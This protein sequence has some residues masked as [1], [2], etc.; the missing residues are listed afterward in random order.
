MR[1]AMLRFA[2][3]PR[4]TEIHSVDGYRL[5]E[6]SLY[7]SGQSGEARSRHSTQL[8]A[9]C[10]DSVFVD[11]R[12]IGSGQIVVIRDNEES[13]I[14]LRSISGLT[15]F[16][17]QAT[18]PCYLDMTGLTH[19]TWAA[20]LKGALVAK[21]DLRVVYVEPVHYRFNRIRTQGEL[22]DLSERF[23]GIGPLPGFLSLA[24]PDENDVIFVPLLGFEGTRFSMVL[25]HVEVPRERIVPIVGVPGF[26]PEFVFYAYQGNRLPLEETRS[27]MEVQYAAANCPF[28]LFYKLEDLLQR[29]DKAFFRIAPIGTKP[30][31]LGAILF[32][33]AHPDRVE[34]IYDHPE[35]RPGRTTG[36]AR[37]LIYHVAAL[38]EQLQL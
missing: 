2:D 11:V 20:L 17:K 36:L 37:M 13:N 31:S 32:A 8:A 7:V 21:V 22:F 33:L 15:E 1:A 16:W 5:P 3:R 4:F 38:R 18:L 23:E 10:P 25:N 24:E 27:W 30:H 6:P 19:P 29:S 26:R 12:E 14:S 34:L 35:R 9:R 28:S